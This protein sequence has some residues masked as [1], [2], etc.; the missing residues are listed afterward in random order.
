MLFAGLLVF[1][2]FSECI[3]KAPTLIVSNVN[4]VK[5]VVFPL[6]VLPWVSLYSAL[7][8]GFISLIAW[9]F[10]YCIF[11]GIPQYT[12]F[13]IPLVVM[14]LLLMIM[15]ISWVL[16]AL[17]VYLRDLSQIIGLFVSALMFL[18]PIFYKLSSLPKEFQL[19]MMLNPLTV[20]VEEIRSCLFSGTNL[21]FS[22]LI[23]YWGGSIFICFIGFSWF[24]KT[25]KGFSDVL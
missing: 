11:Y 12:I 8:H 14:P 25:R 17:G 20:P 4:Y 6:E 21:S 3:V 16:A 19:M 22:H 7:F 1:N 5:K 10:A 2:L 23:F 15:G 9:L 13:Y 24:Q 18:S